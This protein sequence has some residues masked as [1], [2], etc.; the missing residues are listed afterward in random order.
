MQK[1]DTQREQH[2]SAHPVVRGTDSKKSEFVPNG[3]TKKFLAFRLAIHLRSIK[4]YDG[5]L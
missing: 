1:T 3:G 4:W 2:F 5:P